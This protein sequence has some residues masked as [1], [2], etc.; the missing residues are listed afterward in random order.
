MS[1]RGKIKRIA[2]KDRTH[3][4]KPKSH[5]SGNIPGHQGLNGQPVCAF[6]EN[7]LRRLRGQPRAGGS[8]LVEAQHQAILDSGCGYLLL[9]DTALI[10]TACDGR[11]TVKSE[12][13]LFAVMQDAAGREFFLRS[14]ALLVPELASPILLPEAPFLQGCPECSCDARC[15]AIDAHTINKT[16]K[17]LSASGAIINVEFETNGRGI[18]PTRLAKIDPQ[19][20]SQNIRR[21]FHTRPN[22]PQLE[23]VETANALAITAYEDDAA[24]HALAVTEYSA[25]DFDAR[26]NHIMLGHQSASNIA[27]AIKEGILIPRKS[28]PMTSRHAYVPRPRRPLGPNIAA[29]EQLSRTRSCT[30]T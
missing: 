9:R 11:L 15:D 19:R 23:P 14:R 4:T 13:V 18:Y 24:A 12:L 29:R 1:R 10:D 6:A 30:S 21:I 16:L 17:V 26:L 25:A 22:R 20:Y 27:E 2:R 3:G 28:N 7:E 5:S 8:D